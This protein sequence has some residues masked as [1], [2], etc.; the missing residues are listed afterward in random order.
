MFEEEKQRRWSEEDVQ[1]AVQEVIRCKNNLQRAEAKGRKPSTLERWRRMIAEAEATVERIRTL[2][3]QQEQ[4]D[5]ADVAKADQWWEVAQEAVCAYSVNHACALFGKRKHCTCYA[6]G[7]GGK[8]QIVGPKTSLWKQRSIC[9]HSRV[10]RM[11]RQDTGENLDRRNEAAAKNAKSM[12]GTVS[13]TEVIDVDRR[14][15]RSRAAT[16]GIQ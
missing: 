13:L 4:R 14:T 6:V 7:S 1:A 5:A 9:I 12:C 10:C 2:L 11:F 3:R 15:D 16:A 8:H